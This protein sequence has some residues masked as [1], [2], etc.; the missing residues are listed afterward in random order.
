MATGVWPALDN[1]CT[2][3]Q[4]GLVSGKRYEDDPINSP[5]CIVVGDIDEY[6]SVQEQLS[7]AIQKYVGRVFKHHRDT[8]SK[9]FQE[10]H[11]P[12]VNDADNTPEEKVEDF[13]REAV[14]G[15]LL[16]QKDAPDDI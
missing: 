7:D 16:L 2:M 12:R 8:N 15:L 3:N 14:L 5:G 13:W 4:Y 1:L 10:R 11:L 6:S 9:F